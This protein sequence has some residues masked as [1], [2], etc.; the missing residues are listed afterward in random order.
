MS[1]SIQV[2]LSPGQKFA[3]VLVSLVAA[4]ALV[5]GAVSLGLV[6]NSNPVKTINQVT[7]SQGEI[8]AI[9]GSGLS[10]VP[11]QATHSVNFT[12]TGV[13][14]LQAGANIAISASTGD[15]VQI[16][17]TAKPSAVVAGAGIGVANT[18]NDLYTVSNT[19][20]RSVTA[21]L[22]ISVSAATGDNVQIS[23]TT[24]VVAGPGISVTNTSNS[25]FNVTNSGILSIIAGNNITV[26]NNNGHVTINAV[27][28]QGG[29]GG[30]GISSA[31]FGLS[32]NGSSIQHDLTYQTNG[33]PFS[34]PNSAQVRYRTQVHVPDNEWYVS[35]DFANIAFTF[36]TISD[37]NGPDDGQGN[38][39]GNRNWH[40][41][42]SGIYHVHATAFCTM[43]FNNTEDRHYAG[44]MLALNST[45]ANP[46]ISSSL[47]IGGYE[48]RQINPWI[49]EA[50]QN[51]PFSV[52]LSGIIQACPA[53][54][55]RR[56]GQR[57][58]MHFTH[59]IFN[60]TTGGVSSNPSPSPMF[61][62]AQV[63]VSK[64]I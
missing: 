1:K 50:F 62:D 44:F 12:N 13:R 27:N 35:P 15:N 10:I 17:S 47:V 39:P 48:F 52:S 9:A 49:S 42:S 58:T 40:V 32:V 41:P 25:V 21:G 54:C 16:S 22:G 64:A 6:N 53:P 55:A 11:S 61:C 18:T 5:V 31:Q 33:L 56:P 60:S 28:Q 38:Q 37:N 46:W 59:S 2:S 3:V 8:K 34:D 63:F 19:G 4:V 51:V 24:R 14:S 57:L 45:A 23:A 26:S 36:G 20:V 7:P 29:G 43:Y 30:G